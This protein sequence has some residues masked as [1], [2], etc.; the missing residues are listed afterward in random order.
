MPRKKL[1]I[2]EHLKQIA[3]DICEN[4]CKFQAEY[5]E[6]ERNDGHDPEFEEDWS[7]RLYDDHCRNCPL[8]EFF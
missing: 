6:K 3:D 1:T 8:I 2:M 5:L 4:K 7:L